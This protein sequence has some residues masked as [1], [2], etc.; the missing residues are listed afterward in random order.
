MI[1]TGRPSLSLSLSL[2]QSRSGPLQDLN[3]II[4]QR[5]KP[6][7]PGDILHVGMTR[8]SSSNRLLR[9]RKWGTNHSED[10]AAS[11]QVLW[12]K[13]TSGML[14]RQSLLTMHTYDCQMIYL[15]WCAVGAVES[16]AQA[17]DSNDSCNGG[18]DSC[19]HPHPYVF[20]I[21]EAMAFSDFCETVWYG[22]FPTSL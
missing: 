18:N 3:V 13:F 6:W 4:D 22:F 5:C 10:D 20:Q 7:R 21:D 19:P 12:H 2:L 9:N 8:N 11:N 1:D 17:A 16:A 15:Q 14:D